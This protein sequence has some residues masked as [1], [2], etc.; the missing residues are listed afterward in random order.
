MSIEQHNNC[1][2]EAQPKPC[3]SHREAS[4]SGQGDGHR[5]LAGFINRAETFPRLRADVSSHRS[6]QR[7][8]QMSRAGD[9][10]REEPR[11]ILPES[12]SGPGSVTT[13]RSCAWASSSSLCRAPPCSISHR[14]LA[15]ELL[16]LPTKPFQ[17]RGLIFPGGVLKHLL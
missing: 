8:S 9:P 7:C 2:L 10:Q 3:Q 17:L 16:H 4:Q 11:R 13:A 1:R 6:G 5:A 14:S 12:C 15:N